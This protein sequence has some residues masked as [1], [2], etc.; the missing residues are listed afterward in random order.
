MY[1]KNIDK[2]GALDLNR[3][4]PLPAQTLPKCHADMSD[5]PNSE[6]LLDNACNVIA[7]NARII[8]TIDKI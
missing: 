2:A 4:P 3:I 8:V 5:C 7:R 1:S 6:S